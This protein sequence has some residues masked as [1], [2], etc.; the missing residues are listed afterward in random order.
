MYLDI[1]LQLLRVVIGGVV[2]MHGLL[3]LGLVG[4]GGGSI[5]GVAGLV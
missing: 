2:L 3:K 5:A 1:A 4:K